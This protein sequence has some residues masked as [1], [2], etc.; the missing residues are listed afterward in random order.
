MRT[1]TDPGLARVG[2]DGALRLAL[3]RRGAG[4]VL[5]RCGYTL[6]LQVLAPVALDD[7]AAVVSILNPTGGVLGGDRL[8]IDV[9]AG[10][11]AHAVLTTPSANRVYRAPAAPATQAVRL[12]L[13][14][15]AILEWVPDHTI[16][17]PGSAFRQAIDAEVDDGAVLVLVDA[18]AAGRIARG[19]AWRFALL[20]S[21][22]S[23]RDRAGLVLHDR[24]VLGGGRAAAGPGFA[25]GHAYFASVVVVADRGLAAFAAA[26]GRVLAGVAGA[27]GGV[28]MLPRRGALVRCLAADAPA[29]GAALDA[30]WAA[31]RREL[32]GLPPLALRKP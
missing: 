1:S 18:F 2:R 25:E 32:A 15:G 29:L 28:A 21:A 27:T 6:P 13:G 31:A 12:R 3:E 17:Y 24:F 10:P 4:T 16:P 14:A 26:A 22:V 20:E 30:L 9:E 8:R 19:E 23:V 11:A 5:V 7:P